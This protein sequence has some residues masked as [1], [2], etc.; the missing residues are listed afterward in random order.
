M[1]ATFIFTARS[2]SSGVIRTTVS[3]A[4]EPEADTVIAIAAAATLSGASDDQVGVG[5]TEGEIERLHLSSTDALHHLRSCGVL[6][7]ATVL[8][9]HLWRPQDSVKP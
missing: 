1:N 7:A 6:G 3:V 2:T 5:L 9:G 8:D 4:T